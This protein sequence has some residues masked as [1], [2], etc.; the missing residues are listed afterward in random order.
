M[1]EYVATICFYETKDGGR[2]SK[3]SSDISFRPILVFNNKNYH[4]QIVFEKAL[5]ISPGDNIKAKIRVLDDCP[6]EGGDKFVLQEY[7]EIAEGNIISKL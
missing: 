6:I 2:K 7:N 4:C 1:K 3:L 5:L